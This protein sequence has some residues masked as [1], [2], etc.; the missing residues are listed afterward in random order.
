MNAFRLLAFMIDQLIIT[1]VLCIVSF[2]INWESFL[3]PNESNSNKPFETFYPLLAVALIIFYM[4]DL[5]GG[6]SIGKRIFKLAVRDINNFNETP[7]GFRLF[8]RNISLIIWPVELIF[9]LITKKRIGDL[10]GRTQVIRIEQ[11]E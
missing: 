10:V 2:I 7:H 6:R 4:K 5:F 8:I 1:F 9:F 3:L 11:N